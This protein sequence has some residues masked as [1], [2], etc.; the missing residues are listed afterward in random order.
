MAILN[1]F[2]QHN[3][4]INCLARASPVVQGDS[5]VRIIILAQIKAVDIVKSPLWPRSKLWTL[6][7]QHSGPDQSCGYCQI[8]TLAQTKAVDIVKSPLW[9]RSSCG[10]CQITTLAQIKAVDIVKS[11]LWPRSKLWILSN[12]H[13]GPD[14]SC[15]H[16]QI[17]TLAVD[18]VKS[19]LWP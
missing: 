18:I 13:S 15:G 6:S 3:Y 1:H 2:P 11:T 12:H 8:N 7:N 9:P 4:S 17:T 14:Q 19:P 16:C 10:H 5:I